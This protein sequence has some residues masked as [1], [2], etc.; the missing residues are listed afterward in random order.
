MKMY[1]LCMIKKKRADVRG[2][3]RREEARDG[4]I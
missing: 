1:V 4:K 2:S 3:K